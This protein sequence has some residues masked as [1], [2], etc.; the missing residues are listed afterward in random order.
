MVHHTYWNLA[1][2]R[3]GDIKDHVLT[4]YADQYTPGLPPDGKV[5]PVAGTPFDFTQAEAA[6]AAISMKTGDKPP[7]YD[8]NWI[9]DGEPHALRP[10]ARVTSPSRAA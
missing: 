10:V 5:L 9:V 8:S 1:P 2:A 6:S 3:R 4:L 7:G